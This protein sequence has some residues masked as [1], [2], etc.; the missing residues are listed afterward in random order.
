[1]VK[2]DS[3]IKTLDDLLA[4]S[5]EKEGGLKWGTTFAG[6]ADH[7]AIHTLMKAA[8]NTPYT[9]VPF[10]GG[11]AI[12]TNLVGGNVDAALLNY[13]EGETQFGAGEL[14]AIAVLADERIDSLPD[15]PTGKEAGVDATAATIRGFVALKGVPEDRLKKLE[16]G[17]VEAM[18]HSVYQ[19]YLASG[20]MPKSSVVGSDKWTAQIRQIYED[21]TTALKELGM[22]K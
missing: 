2:A 19:T 10:K 14:R 17:L 21:S 13:A 11:G 20:G 16:E 22:L 5:K 12:V 9:I 4:A 8:D 3:P 1:M 7:V 15:T 6:G 18:E